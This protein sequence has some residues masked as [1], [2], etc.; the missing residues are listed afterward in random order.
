MISWMLDGEGVQGGVVVGLGLVAAVIDSLAGVVV[1]RDADDTGGDEWCR[2]LLQGVRGPK[3]PGTKRMCLWT[4]AEHCEQLEYTCKRVKNVSNTKLPASGAEL[5]IDALERLESPTDMLIM[6]THV[7]SVVSDPQRP[8]NKSEHVRTPKTARINQTYL[9]EAPNHT[10]RNH[11]ESETTRTHHVHACTC[12][13]V[14]SMQEQPQEPQE[15]S[16]HPQRS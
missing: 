15:L 9:A 10:Q 11:R 5:H 7:Q 14:K 4:H 1:L 16:K 6:S 12:R 3:R 2:S 8:E 13:V